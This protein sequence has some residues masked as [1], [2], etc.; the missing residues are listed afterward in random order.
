[1]FGS[2]VVLF[3]I[4]GER[5]WNVFE[6]VCSRKKERVSEIFASLLN[7][8]EI[9]RNTSKVMYHIWLLPYFSCLLRNIHFCHCVLVKSM[10]WD[11]AMKEFT[12]DSPTVLFKAFERFLHS[13]FMVCFRNVLCLR[14]KDSIVE[15]M[16]FCN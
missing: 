9:R 6:S 11:T 16:K 1:M 14:I 8:E 3:T 5:R 4:K 15:N 2:T 12:Q 7:Y 10:H 13:H